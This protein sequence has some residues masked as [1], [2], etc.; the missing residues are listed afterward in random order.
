MIVIKDFSDNTNPNSVIHILN[1]PLG[2]FSSEAWNLYFEIVVK[3][4]NDSCLKGL[5]WRQVHTVP[6]G[7][8]GWAR[9]A[10]L[11]SPRW[12]ARQSGCTDVY[13]SNAVMIQL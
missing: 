8:A 6:A 10:A 12:D 4:P 5:C 9:R 3:S 13:S 7:R 2:N 1:L 11:S